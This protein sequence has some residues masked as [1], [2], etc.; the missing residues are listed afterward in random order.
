MRVGIFNNEIFWTPHFGTGL[1]IMEGHLQNGDEV[2]SF[3]CDG[4]LRPCD[5][6]YEK[7]IAKC[8]VCKKKR[9]LGQKQLSGKVTNI[10]I[11]QN[12]QQLNLVSKEMSVDE[13]KEVMYNGYDAGMAA[14][15]SIVTRK[16]DA[17]L[18]VAKNFDL[19]NDVVNH[20]A[21]LYEF[22]K[23]QI[24]INKIEKAYIFNGLF[25]YSR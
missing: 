6:N 12:D 5:Q 22:F 14:I 19:I 17:Y 23:E 18:D 16:R 2:Y 20:S 21:N 25:A 1:E 24:K 10:K 7:S 9:Q 11:P 8:K 13:V 3:V 4:A 15:S